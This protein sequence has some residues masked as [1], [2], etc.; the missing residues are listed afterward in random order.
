[1]TNV[2]PVGLDREAA[3]IWALLACEHETLGFRGFVSFFL[4][5]LQNTYQ[6]SD[7]R[8]IQFQ[9]LQEAEDVCC[10]PSP[11]FHFLEV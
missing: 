7:N 4:T 5:A 6:M 2:G 9:H 11:S 10:S 1:M 8:Y 3:F